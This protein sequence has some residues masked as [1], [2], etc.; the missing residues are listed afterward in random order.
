MG[1]VSFFVLATER[2]LHD[3]SVFHRLALSNLQKQGYTNDIYG[4][5]NQLYVNANMFK[6]AFSYTVYDNLN[7]GLFTPTFLPGQGIDPSASTNAFLLRPPLQATNAH[8]TYGPASG[9]GANTFN[10]INF[11][12]QIMPQAKPNAWQPF[13]VYEYLHNSSV[14]VLNN[15]Y[16]V[17]VGATKGNPAK[18]GAMTAWFTWRDI[19]ADATLATFADSDLGGGTDYRGYQLGVAWRPYDSLQF[20]LAYH[21]FDGAPNKTNS[22]QRFFFDVARYF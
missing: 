4:V 18:R 3:L 5:A 6:A 8:Y 21:N 20:R 7:S 15:G 11:T 17:S 9:F 22:V 2:T 13:L 19:D 16:G 1:S 12:G 14:S 10:L